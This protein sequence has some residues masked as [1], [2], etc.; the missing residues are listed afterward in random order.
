M[1]APFQLPGFLSTGVGAVVLVVA[2]LVALRFLGKILHFAIRIALVVV[3]VALAL[4]L[5][6]QAGLAGLP[7]AVSNFLAGLHL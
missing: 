6:H 7:A 1:T 5:F 4:Y 2:G 3:L